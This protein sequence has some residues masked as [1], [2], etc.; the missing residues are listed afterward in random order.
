[1]LNR[2]LYYQKQYKL[3]AI[4]LIQTRIIV[5]T[6]LHVNVKKKFITLNAI[7]PVDQR[8]VIYIYELSNFFRK[9]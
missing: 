2:S 6:L 5:I 7:A 1:M 8:L 3:L 9:N 4:V